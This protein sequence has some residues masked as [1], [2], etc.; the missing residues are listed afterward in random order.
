[1]FS[2][3][4]TS[5][6]H[7]GTSHVGFFKYPA[8]YLHINKLCLVCT[9]QQSTK[10]YIICHSHL[11]N[12]SRKLDSLSTGSW[13]DLGD[14]S[15][16]KASLI[17]I[18]QCLRLLRASKV[19]R[20]HVISPVTRADSISTRNSTRAPQKP[21]FIS[22]ELWEGGLNKKLSMGLLLCSVAALHSRSTYS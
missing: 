18:P 2:S 19:L 11:W 13:G 4:L 6:S 22:Q 14:S 1:M 15:T 5:F 12:I 21:Q 17:Q 8:W 20:A 16:D 10:K 7:Q 9:V 3:F